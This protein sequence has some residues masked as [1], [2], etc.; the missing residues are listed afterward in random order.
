SRRTSFVIPGREGSSRARN[1]QSLLP[2]IDRKDWD[3][4]FR[5]SL[6]SAGM[7]RF[8][9]PR[10]CKLLL[11]R[12][13]RIERGGIALTG[14]LVEALDR[15]RFAQIIDQLRLSAAGDVILQLSFD[16]IVSR[17]R[18]YALVF[19]LN[20][21]PAKLRLDRIRNL[22]LVELERRFGEFRHHLIFG[23]PAKIAAFG[24]AWILGFFLGQSGEIRAL[25]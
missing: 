23:E 22:T 18:L 17:R 7:T 19:D 12:R 20:D 25:L 8:Y 16:L 9:A 13:G 2:R 15:R 24:R 1:P 6:G 14:R 5:H 11:R 4:G 21:V 10:K 3:Y